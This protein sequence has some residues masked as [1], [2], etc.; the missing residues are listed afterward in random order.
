MELLPKHCH[1]LEG[2][3][4]ALGGHSSAARQNWIAS[5]ESALSAAKHVYSGQPTK[6]W[7]RAF[8]QTVDRSG[9]GG[10]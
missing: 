8:T 6:D 9:M 10:K 4:K 2:E 1:L 5:M 3:F 7:H